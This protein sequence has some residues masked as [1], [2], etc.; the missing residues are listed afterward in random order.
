ME[1]TLG[2]KDADL[3]NP[4][5]NASKDAN[6]DSFKREAQDVGPG[7]DSVARDKDTDT[8]VVSHKLKEIYGIDDLSKFLVSHGSS[9]KT[10]VQ[11]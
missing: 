11:I 4:P 2:S 5:D 8:E 3:G 9:R 7:I 10:F 1:K 6:V